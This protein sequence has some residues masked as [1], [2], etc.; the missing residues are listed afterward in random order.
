[1]V[2]VPIDASKTNSKGY[3]NDLPSHAAN[4]HRPRFQTRSLGRTASQSSS[5]PQRPD[6]LAEVLHP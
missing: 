2:H 1:M 5:A 4:E 3:L 6:A